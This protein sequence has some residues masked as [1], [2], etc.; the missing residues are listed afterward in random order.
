MGS[1]SGMPIDGSDVLAR[2]EAAY[3]QHFETEPARA[4]VSF[5][6]V[7][8]IEILL[9]RY[10]IGSVEFSTYASLG[11][12]RHPMTAA[13]ETVVSPSD[14]RAELVLTVRNSSAEVWRQLA[15]LAAAPAVESVVYRPLARIDLGEPWLPGSRCSGA[16]IVAAQ[17]LPVPVDTG[18][19]DILKVLPATGTELAWARVHG[20][21]ELVR[22]WEDRHTDLADLFRAAVGLD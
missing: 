21:E 1:V 12:S 15:V 18:Q 16:L 13:G 19:V 14:P 9:Y 11:M 22:R 2:V 20:S 3:H 6:G 5:V 10:D 8:P 7:D 17:L 4:S